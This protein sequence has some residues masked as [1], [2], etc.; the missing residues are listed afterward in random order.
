VHAALARAEAAAAPVASPLC[1]AATTQLAALRRGAVPG[2]LTA[3]ARACASG[4]AAEHSVVAIGALAEVLAS[5]AQVLDAALEPA[6]ATAAR[7]WLENGVAADAVLRAAALT[8]VATVLEM[9]AAEVP[10]AAEPGVGAGAVVGAGDGTAGAGAGTEASPPASD[11]AS[12]RRCGMLLDALGKACGRTEGA[13]EVALVT[14]QKV[15][16]SQSQRLW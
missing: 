3:V 2:L 10:A 15:R 9:A 14:L 4:S 8:A 11:A 16:G 13:A 12:S 5:D 7:E 1:A 6:R